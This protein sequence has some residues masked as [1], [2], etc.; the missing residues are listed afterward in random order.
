MFQI[1]AQF[2]GRTHQWAPN[3]SYGILHDEGSGQQHD[4]QRLPA[5]SF[6]RLLKL[7]NLRLETI[8]CFHDGWIPSVGKSR[9]AIE[10]V[11]PE[12]C[13]VERRAGLL[14][15]LWPDLR[16]GDVIELAFEFDRVVRPNRQ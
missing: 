14:N 1:F 6:Y 10:R 5:G 9:N 13:Q 12:A 4:I 15:R 3:V 7:F 11:L 8:E 16:F 2:V